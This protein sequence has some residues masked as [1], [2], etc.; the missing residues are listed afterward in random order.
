MGVSLLAARPPRPDGARRPARVAL[1]R[2]PLLQLP[3]T[4]SYFGAIP[5]VGLAYVAA[6][7]RG[8]GHA[9]FTVDAPGEALDRVRSVSSPVGPLHMSGLGPEEIVERLPADLDLVGVSHMFLHEWP[10]IRDMA[11]R[12]KAARPG[13]PIVLG[14][15]NATSCW[16][17]LME[18][19]QAID[20]C[21]LGEGEE[22]ALELVARAVAGR[23]WAGMPGLAWRDDQGA[24]RASD[25]R[26]R[27]RTLTD[28]PRP[29]WDL[30]PLD[31]YLTQ[32]NPFGVHRGRSLPI[33]GSRGCPYACTFC[34]S[35]QMWSQRYV[36]RPPADVVA[37]MEEMVARH[38]VENFDFADL[39]V[40]IRK[41]WVLEFCHLLGERALGVTWQLPVG[42]RTEMLDAEVLR[43]LHETGCR[44]VTFAPESGSPR[45]LE[46]MHKRVDLD[47]MLTAIRQASQV[48]LM[49]GVNIILGHPA[50]T[51]EDALR[52]LRF[53]GQA[54]MAGA[55]SCSVMLFAPYPGS[56]DFDA[57]VESG[58]LVFDERIT[59][60]SLT[61]TGMH[62]RTYNRSMSTTEI[63][64]LRNAMLLAFYGASHVV[65]PQRIVRFFRNQWS[66]REETVLDQFARTKRHQIGEAAA[67]GWRLLTGKL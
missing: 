19:C 66:G 17:H 5:P 27:I 44:N 11:Q 64:A 67:M 59:Y 40:F 6:V 21:V 55:A 30:F 7:L 29:A 56:S 15:E 8:A 24:P 41:A 32:S 12:I 58:D 65:H 13:V 2:P 22:V 47:A 38:R 31:S 23:S 1:I 26:H 60:Q 35:R 18:G 37:E 14:G 53:I 3:R 54:V 4:L 20:A 25:Q 45:L 10:V 62:T 33:L 46:V 36:A 57:L 50:E 51:R 39:T 16:R 42:T 9:V 43:L 63:L 28:M 34:S 52:S 48:G 61:R 49:V